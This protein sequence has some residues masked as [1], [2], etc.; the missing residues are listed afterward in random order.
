LLAPRQSKPG[1]QAQPC[2]A[3]SLLRPRGRQAGRQTESQECAG[4]ARQS[5]QLKRSTKQ[6]RAHTSRA[7]SLEVGLEPGSE[8][9]SSSLRS[10][11]YSTP[12]SLS[13]SLSLFLSL[14]LSIVLQ[15]PA[16]P[17]RSHPRASTASRTGRR[18]ARCCSSPSNHSGPFCS[19]ARI[20]RARTHAPPI[21]SLDVE[22]CR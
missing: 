12:L 2:A 22:P 15:A 18:A 7:W 10:L 14:S 6:Y 20:D 13:F 17:A 19:V 5:I 4:A 9:R 21:L 1:E 8:V 3:S 16:R 11:V